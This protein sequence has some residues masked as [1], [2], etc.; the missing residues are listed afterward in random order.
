[1]PPLIVQ[2]RQRGRTS[3]SSTVAEVNSPAMSHE[4]VA[5]GS[6]RHGL[7]RCPIRLRRPD[8]VGVLHPVELFAREVMP[9]LQ[10]A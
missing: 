7:F 10:D 2:R 8:V 6:R 5:D 9:A 4:Q 3:I 1:L